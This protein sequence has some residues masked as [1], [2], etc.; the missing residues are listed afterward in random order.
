MVQSLVNFC[1]P[2]VGCADLLALARMKEGRTHRMPTGGR[3][4]LGPEQGWE[5]GLGWE[6]LWQSWLSSTLRVVTSV[7]SRASLQLYRG[8]VPNFACTREVQEESK[9]GT[10]LC[11]R[12]QESPNLS[13]S[14]KDALKLVNKPPFTCGPGTSLNVAFMLSVRMNAITRESFRWSF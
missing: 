6:C 14:P 12:P 11:L 10:Q 9:N 7:G 13:L 3:A 8:C 2:A 1:I 5:T 4:S